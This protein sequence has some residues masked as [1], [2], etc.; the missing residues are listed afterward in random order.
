MDSPF[1]FSF[2]H[3]PPL[4]LAYFSE[5]LRCCFFSPLKWAK[6]IEKWGKIS[7]SFSEKFFFPPPLGWLLFK[8]GQ[9]QKCFYSS[10]TVWADPIVSGRVH[11]NPLH[12]VGVSGFVWWFFLFGGGMGVCVLCFLFFFF[13]VL[14]QSTTFD[15]VSDPFFFCSFVY[16]ILCRLNRKLQTSILMYLQASKLVQTI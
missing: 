14:L 7:P 11:P 1:I 9:T 10:C 5:V 15:N 13:F 3:H 8:C 16:L 2:L 12:T 4:F 6:S